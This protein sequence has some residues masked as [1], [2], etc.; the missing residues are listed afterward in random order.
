MR[1]RSRRGLNKVSM[2]HDATQKNTTPPFRSG[3]LAPLLKRPP[4][5][6]SRRRVSPA[7]VAIALP[8][9]AAGRLAESHV[10]EERVLQGVGQRQPLG[11]LVLQHAFDE[12]E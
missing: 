12:V 8:G 7:D 9:L 1:P 5:R 4:V 11:R 3:P 10:F 2:L 6:S